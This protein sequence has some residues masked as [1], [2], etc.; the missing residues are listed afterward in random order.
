MRSRFV[1]YFSEDSLAGYIIRGAG[2]AV[3]WRVL[4]FIGGYM[5]SIMISNRLGAGAFGLYSI[6]LS[7]LAL[8]TIPAKLGLDRALIRLLAEKGK[9][10]KLKYRSTSLL[11]KSYW[12]AFLP[13]CLSALL[14]YFLAPLIAIKVYDNQNLVPVIQTAA[15]TV[16]P[17]AYLMIGSESFRGLSRAGAYSFTQHG[18]RQLLPLSI[19]AV[20]F[21]F[22][23]DYNV[24]LLAP[25]VFFFG[26]SMAAVFTGFH[27]F[28]TA[29]KLSN[30]EGEAPPSAGSL[31][32]LAVPMM[33]AASAL[34][35][36][37]TAD[38][39]MLRIFESDATVGK[40][41]AAIKLAAVISF[42]I[43]SINTLAGP[44]FSRF[45]H[46]GDMKQFKQ[47][48]RF[49]SKLISVATLPVLLLI[50]FFPESLLE[51]FGPE[52]VEAKSSL[53]ILIVG[54]GF[55]AFAG[56]VDLILQMTGKQKTFQWILI[57]STVLNI[58]LNALLI[59]AY[60]MEGAAIA[61]TVS[62]ILWNLSSLIY[63]RRSFGFWTNSLIGS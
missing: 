11:A 36:S 47:S 42:S 8:S 15:F 33:L 31:V 60:G 17:F 30:A 26:I 56:P 48:V 34:V 51:L 12:I 37:S 3:F 35:I 41:N 29:G 9:E 2:L 27:L 57:S 52:F 5:L 53:Y 10:G 14:L 20:I 32:N 50:V 24:D 45:Y 18:L 40:Y 22:P 23:I 49:V 63:A 4:G 19:L 62:L 39:L 46:S 1:K 6:F 16:I 59:P 25:R 38:T 28:S 43:A 13:V 54:Y 58:A 21:I 61:T 55:N 44:Q 7:L